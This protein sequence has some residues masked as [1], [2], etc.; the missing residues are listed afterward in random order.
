MKHEIIERD[1]FERSPEQVARDLIGM[2]LVRQ[3]RGQRLAG[4]IVETEAYLANDDSASHAARGRTMSN[5]AM[6]LRPGTAYVYPIHAKFCFNVV[7]E[8]MGIGS[9][10]LIRALEPLEGRPWM[11][12][13]R[14]VSR[15][16]DLTNGPAK[17]CQAMRI[18][19]KLDKHDLTRGVS[20]WIERELETTDECSRIIV[21]PRIGVSSA[22][23]L[24]LR[25][26]AAEHPYASGSRQLNRAHD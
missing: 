15:T 10:V 24:P 25:F 23:K 21:T 20:L 16:I 7:T 19:R 14:P 12:R 26:V 4:L 9:A 18:T 3:W 11:Q 6:F 2:R 8:Q 17:L 1:W 5:A 22:T 13:Y